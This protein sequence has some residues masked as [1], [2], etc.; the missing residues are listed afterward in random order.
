MLDALKVFGIIL[1]VLVAATLIAL[2][3]ILLV[4]YLEPYG[5]VVALGSI[6]VYL[7]AMGTAFYK[8]MTW[9]EGR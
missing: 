1:A 9:G 4:V 6:F 5:A 8:F 7:A 2:P 3:V